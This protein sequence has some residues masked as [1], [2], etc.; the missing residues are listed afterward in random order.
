MAGAEGQIVAEAGGSAGVVEVGVGEFD[1]RVGLGVGGEIAPAAEV[2][3][4]VK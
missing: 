3:E 4:K 2:G 1:R